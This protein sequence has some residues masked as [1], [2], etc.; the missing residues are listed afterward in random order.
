MCYLTTKS[1]HT[2]A[3]IYVSLSYTVI[4][5]PPCQQGA[6]C[7]SYNVCNCPISYYGERCELGTKSN[8]FGVQYV[9]DFSTVV[10]FATSCRY[11]WMCCGF[12]QLWADLQQH[13]GR[14][15]LFL[16]RWIY[17]L[18]WWGFLY[19]YIQCWKF[20]PSHNTIVMRKS[21]HGQRI[22]HVHQRGEGGLGGG[23][24]WGERS[25]LLTSYT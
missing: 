10:L 9:G 11:W 6:P 13:S 23:G 18:P 7:I 22:L 5:D 20:T 17:S 21:T 14:L 8:T 2:V 24:I 12:T 25:T 19:R 1:Y 15:Q 3:Y 4:C 16:S